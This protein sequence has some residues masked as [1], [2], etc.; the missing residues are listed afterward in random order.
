MTR[1]AKT[2]C[3]AFVPVFPICDAYE[4]F[5][6]FRARM[7]CGGDQ[8]ERAGW[9]RI[10]MDAQPPREDIQLRRRKGTCKRTDQPQL[11]C[12]RLRRRVLNQL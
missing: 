12:H 1:A 11:Q 9:P 3:R 10:Q 7:P 8:A 5:T 2:E 4:K 6:S